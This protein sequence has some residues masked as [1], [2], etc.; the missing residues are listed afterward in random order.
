MC[1]CV[2]PNWFCIFGS[3]FPEGNMAPKGFVL[4]SYSPFHIVQL[5]N[6]APAAQR[7]PNSCWTAAWSPMLMCTEISPGWM[8]VR[9]YLPGRYW[10]S[11]CSAWIAKSPPSCHSNV[12]FDTGVWDVAR[13]AATHHK[14]P[15]CS[16]NTPSH[17][18]AKFS[19]DCLGAVSFCSDLHSWAQFPTKWSKQT[20]VDQ[21]CFNHSSRSP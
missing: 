19:R 11:S 3:P 20:S 7:K 12:W 6:E 8:S 16:Y 21:N 13:S 9:Q 4:E 15:E 14:C 17:D 1:R 10:E 5:L 2:H 18:N